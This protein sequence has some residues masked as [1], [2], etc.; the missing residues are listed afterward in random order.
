M[1][2]WSTT[3]VIGPLILI[4]SNLTSIT[5]YFISTKLIRGQKLQI[6]NLFNAIIT[7]SIL[8]AFLN[9]IF[10]TPLFLYVFTDVKTINFIEISNNYNSG[11]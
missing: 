5:I 9:G 7:N 10:F 4:I 6:L 11:L 8:L 1:I 3:G 2:G